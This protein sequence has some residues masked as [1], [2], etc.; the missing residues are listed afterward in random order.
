M[1]KD[2]FNLKSIEIMLW[3]LVVVSVVIAIICEFNQAHIVVKYVCRLILNDKC[4]IYLLNLIYIERVKIIF[5]NICRKLIYISIAFSLSTFIFRSIMDKVTKDKLHKSNNELN[6]VM[7][8]YLENDEKRVF[9]VSG[10]WGAG[11][12][13]IVKDFFKIYSRYN[14]IKPHYISCFGI[15]TRKE[16][17]DEIKLSYEKDDNRLKIKLLEFIKATPFIGEGIYKLC[18]PKYDFN[19]MK[20][21]SIFI[22]D[23]FE[24]VISDVLYESSRCRSYNKS[25]IHS[26]YNDPRDIKD[27]KKAIEELENK[28]S[29][30]YNQNLDLVKLN[31]YE[32]LNIMTGIINEINEIYEMKVIIICNYDRLD[33]IFSYEIFDCKMSSIK[34]KVKSNDENIKNT[35]L[36]HIENLIYLEYTK[37]TLIK[38]LINKEKENIIKLWKDSN[39]ENLRVLGGIIASFVDFVE[40]I[41]I[42]KI[43][44]IERNI[45]YSIFIA[46]IS[47][48]K[49]NMDEIKNID[50]G[51]NIVLFNRKKELEY[52]LLYRAQNNAFKF[53]E[54]SEETSNIKWI[55]HN[56]SY[57]WI[58]GDRINIEILEEEL[59]RFREANY[60]IQN[61]LALRETL[62]LQEVE[63]IINEEN[64]FNI[65]DILYV[66]YLLKD[67]NE[68]FVKKIIESE[69]CISNCYDSLNKIEDLLKYMK[70]T[71]CIDLLEDEEFKNVI[72][73]KILKRYDNTEKLYEEC[74]EKFERKGNYRTQNDSIEIFIEWICNNK[75]VSV[76]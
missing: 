10:A 67:K 68:V 50:I 58:V 21:K 33:K 14:S 54:Y 37:V 28:V 56:I 74:I 19:T 20:K 16:L 59:H 31:K 1:I 40:L 39:I 62:N 32:K 45:F 71:N 63:E 47:Y 51:E 44:G 57:Y 22:F 73:E 27:I 36:S 7:S 49:N 29:Y 76:K 9:V 17:I 69:K 12:T 11:K 2:K 41:D 35:I 53:L 18:K 34:Y 61:K 4:Y 46:H 15:S 55:G 43:N 48:F 72:F 42:E 13:H 52:Q 70:N 25:R 30:L 38:N 24:R 66:F 6:R 75:V 3:I 60:E 5:I 23:D 65:E 26:N 8:N 64:K